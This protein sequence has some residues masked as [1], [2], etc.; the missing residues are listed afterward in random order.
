MASAVLKAIDMAV[1]LLLV[2]VTIGYLNAYE[3]GIWLTLNSILMWINSFD[4]GLGNGL[5][6]KLA[7]AIANGDK[8]LA[9]SYVSSTFGM[10]LI[11]VGFIAVFGGLIIPNINWYTLLN[12]TQTQVPNLVPVVLSTF[13]G[14]RINELLQ[15][16]RY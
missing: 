2:P 11:L 3:Y 4:I 13:F 10:L 16:C 12:T 14:G 8:Q 7:E 5:R 1:Y 6:N 9:K 15:N